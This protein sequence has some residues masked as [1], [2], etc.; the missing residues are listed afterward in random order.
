MTR[1]FHRESTIFPGNRAYLERPRVNRLL[2]DALKSPIVTVSAG[3]GYGKTQAV[4]AFLHTYDASAAWIHLSERDNLSSRFW[5]NFARTLALY[6][7][8]IGAR[9]LG[10]GFPE[11][12]EQLAKLLAIPEDELS[13][14]EKYVLV[15]DDF[16]LIE[17]RSVLGF[18]RRVT[19]APF[20][21]ITLV[22]I[23]RVEPD[24]GTLSLLSKGLVVNISEDDLRFTEEETAQ[25]FQLLGLPQPP[26]ALADIHSDTGGWAFAIN[27]I[28]LS[29]KKAPASERRA[30]AAM[31][32]NVFKMIESDAFLAVSERLQ[33]FLIRLSLIDHLS[34]DLIS[35]LADDESLL[36]EME[37]LSSFIRYDIYLNAYLI[38][39]LFLDYLRQKQD[40]LSEEEKRDTYVK[41]AR[42]CD[43]NDFKTDAI[44]YYGK[45][46]EYEAIVSIVSRFPLLVPHEQAKFVL[47]IYEKAPR[48]CLERIAMYHLQHSRLLMSVG[49]YDDAMADISSRIEKYE[50]LPSSDFN[51]Q[52]LCAAY[53]A[54]GVMN[55]RT[56]PFTDRC[57]FDKPMAEGN[58]YYQLSPHE[59]EAVTSVNL[60]AWISRVGTARRGAMEEY[61]EALSRAIPHAMNVLDGFMYGLDDLAHGE[62]LFYRGDMRQAELFCLRALGKAEER[63]QYEVRNRSLFYLMRIG[64][65][66]GGFE[67]VQAW[68]KALEAQLETSDY[69]LRFTSYDIV[70]GW[71]YSAIGQ[72]RLVADW[73][74]GSFAP[75][76]VGDFIASFGNLVKTRFYYADRRYHELLSFVESGQGTDSV[77]FGKLE[78][79]LIEAV[80]RYHTKDRKAALDAL[81]EAYGLAESNDLTMP[82]IELGKDMRTLTASAMRETGLGIPRQWLETINRKAATYAKRLSAVVAEYRKA[83]GMG[84]EVRLSPR[85]TEILGDLCRGL[86]RSQIA[87]ERGLSI[88]TVKLVLSTVYTKLGADNVA[89]AIRIALERKLVSP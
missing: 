51:N 19:Q 16:H 82:F 75:A 56:L 4:Y 77:L 37:K 8:R 26:Q 63:D 53:V 38:H 28:G 42:W 73:L 24:I 54:L 15:F 35:I 39:H 21:N 61:I 34:T 47:E 7:E 87:A 46:G 10:L 44:T 81:C 74:K 88:N 58:R 52:V 66:Q 65:A 62:L 89:D 48:E 20:P 72:Q 64:I 9:M 29:L 41:A 18:F 78:M 6:S 13:P 69:F 31:K 86:S 12:E 55:Y 45:A 11:T 59:Y 49:R 23:S 3:A 1:I 32:L 17:D 68:L 79:K 60:H 57:D 25:Y 40:V 30:R 5:E 85:E 50:A 71:Y 27:L 2:G 83:H 43:E 84:D 36:A 22:L 14:S 33:R 80:C 70:Y 76:A 67:K